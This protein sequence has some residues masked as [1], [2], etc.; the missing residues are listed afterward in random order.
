[1]T[2]IQYMNECMMRDL[3]MMLI[4]KYNVSLSEALDILYNSETFEKLQD[5]RTGLYFQS[6]VY[7]FDFLQKEL[8]R[9]Q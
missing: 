8:S 5:E 2:E 3:A 9:N 6:P 4:K 7:V 1:M